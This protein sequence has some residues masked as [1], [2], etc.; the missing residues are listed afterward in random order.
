MCLKTIPCKLIR[1]LPNPRN[2]ADKLRELSKVSLKFLATKYLLIALDHPSFPCL[3]FP[4]VL[5]S[6]QFTPSVASRQIYHLKNPT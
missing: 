4:L 3:I 1:F 5:V 2:L 6:V